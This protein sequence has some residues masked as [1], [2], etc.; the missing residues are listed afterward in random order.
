[1]KLDW[2]W[3]AIILLALIVAALLFR[4]CSKRRSEKVTSTTVRIDTLRASD[5]IFFPA[6]YR[7]EKQIP[8]LLK[9]DTEAIIEDYFTEKYYSLKYEDTAIEAVTDVKVKG[10]ALEMAK[11]DYKMTQRN[12]FTTQTTFEEPKFFLSAGGGLTY[13]IPNRKP[14][15]ELQLGVGV[16]RSE[17]YVGYDFVNQT[18]RIGW[19]YQF[20]RH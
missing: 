19:Q 16:K 15:F 12:T 1:M 6:P 5:T 17:F 9:V 7:V 2:K 4:N 13:N 10:N 3:F 20:I 14:G 11:L 8:Y 18:P